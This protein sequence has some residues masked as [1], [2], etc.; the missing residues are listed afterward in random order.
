MDKRPA[1]LFSGPCQQSSQHFHHIIGGARCVTRQVCVA[2]A[3]IER[4]ENNKG[5]LLGGLVRDLSN[6]E[7][8]E[9]F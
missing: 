6:S 7:Q 9:K 8:L 1:P 5:I 4:I 3:R 2:K